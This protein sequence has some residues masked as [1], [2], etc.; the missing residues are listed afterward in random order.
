MKLRFAA[1]TLSCGLC[2]LPAAAQS[3]VMQHSEIAFV[4][5]QMGV[6]VE[7]RFSRWS[8][9]LDFDPKRPEQGRVSF[10]IDCGS[11]TFGLAEIDAEMPKPVWFDT[12]RFPK[13]GFASTA[14]TSAGSNR[15]TVAG[16]L[17]LKGTT[18]DVEVPVTL[19]QS[20][21]QGTASGS[22]TIKR[23]DFRIGDGE[24]ADTAILANDVQVKFRLTLTNLA[25]M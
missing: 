7:G 23:L 14:I 3:V 19:A 4:S 2:T 9:Q 8:G 15:F 17:T 10:A 18:R 21:T 6:P 20:G 5:R 22:F 12:L 24:W 25:P 11:A 1:S 13:A 16:K